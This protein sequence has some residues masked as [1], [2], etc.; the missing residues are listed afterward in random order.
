MTLLVTHPFDANS[1]FGTIRVHE[2]TGPGLDMRF[3]IDGL[4]RSMQLS[5]T[6]SDHPV[7]MVISGFNNGRE[8]ERIERLVPV[9]EGKTSASS[10]EKDCK[11]FEPLH[12]TTGFIAPSGVDVLSIKADE[13]DLAFFSTTRK[14]CIN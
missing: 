2:P 10:L 13:H 11:T 7:L 8:V 1:Q 5:L 12:R 14:D 4:G 3:S 6:A 9:C